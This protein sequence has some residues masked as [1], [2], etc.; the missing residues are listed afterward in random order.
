MP[1]SNRELVTTCY[2]SCFSFPDFLVYCESKDAMY[3][4]GDTE[5]LGA[6][7]KGEELAK[8]WIP[9]IDDL[10]PL[11]VTFVGYLYLLFV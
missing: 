3:V 2:Y 5:N 10:P 9:W 1:K 11:P 6:R 7:V 8:L 4:E